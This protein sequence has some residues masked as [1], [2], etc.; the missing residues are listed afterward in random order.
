MQGWF[1]KLIKKE[2]HYNHFLKAYNLF[3]L[4]FDVQWVQ[5][6]SLL[7]NWNDL[8][9]CPQ[10]NSKIKN[11]QYHTNTFW[12]IITWPQLQDSDSQLS[13]VT[14]S[15]CYLYSNLVPV[16]MCF[17]L[18]N[19]GFHVILSHEWVY[20]LIK[21]SEGHKWNL[22]RLFTVILAQLWISTYILLLF[23]RIN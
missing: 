8:R 10:F 6:T 19:I 11:S 20:F 17:L 2:H 21:E 7:S 22:S 4:I 9:N 13:P 15:A 14:V 12:K 23:Q 1:E 3:L 5:S 16:R 18:D